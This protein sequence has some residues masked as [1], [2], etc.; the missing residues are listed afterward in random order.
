MNIKR[1]LQIGMFLM[2]LSLLVACGGNSQQGSSSTGSENNDNTSDATEDQEVI[3][4]RVG[5]IGAPGD[6]Y[7]VGFEEY[8][9]AVEEAT[10]GKVKFEIFGHGQLGGERDLTEQVQM[11]SLDMSVITTGQLGNFVE[12]ITVFEMPFLFRDVEHAYKVLDS[13]IGQEVLDS[14]EQVGFKGIAFW[15]NGNR[16]LANSVRTVKSPEDLKGLKMR[17]LENE[18]FIDA[19]RLLGT[20]P[21]PMAF[22]ELYSSLQQGVV[23]GH[24]S[25]NT[26]LW[27]YNLYEVQPYVSEVGFYYASATLFMNNNFYNSLPA[28]IQETIVELGKEYATFQRELNLQLQIESKEKMTEAG[29]EVTG[30]E[31]IDMDA[32]R[33][34]LEPIYEKYGPK[35]GDLIERIRSM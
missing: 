25:T 10:E 30:V 21:T 9:K 22:P 7:A 2:A 34:A 11:G 6:A 18:V 5:H 28:E 15:E 16:N 32:F 17:T 13:E 24:D 1:I 12:D 3:N 26:I 14:M 27:A 4:I 29:V 33:E 35:Y 31:D 8:A 23:D 20:D 19:Y